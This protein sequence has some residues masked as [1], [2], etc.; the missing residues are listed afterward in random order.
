MDYHVHES[1]IVDDGAKIGN[2]TR[3][4]HFVHVC[5]GAQI[6]EGC[7]LGQNVFV[8]NKVTIGNNVKVQNNV[9]VYD[10]VHIE[11]DVFC[12]PSMVFTNVYNPRSF[13]ERKTEYRDTLVKKGATLGA[14]CTIVC[15][16]TI[17]EYS[18]VGAGAVINKDVPAFA[19]MVGVPA[20]QIG[21][22]SKYGEQLKLPIS[23]TGTEKCEHTGDTYQLL[24]STLT[25]INE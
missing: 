6:G 11:D 19:L 17:G 8:G 25:L 22:I 16:V 20:K 7:S 18:L 2:N 5:S 1:A 24:G 21:W 14:N 15:G 13:I 12:G 9:S 23:G 3:V 10:N 4:W